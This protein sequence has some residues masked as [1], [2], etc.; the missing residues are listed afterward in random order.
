M[1]DWKYV[2]LEDPETG[3]KVPVI[4]PTELTHSDMAEAA[5]RSARRA[6]GARTYLKP[7]SAG[8][9]SIM[10]T[11]TS[12]M[13]ESLNL[14]SRPEDALTINTRPYTG[15]VESGLEKNIETML[16]VKHIE[17]LLERIKS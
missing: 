5:I 2:M 10:T 12:G 7:V 1:S 14:D 9:L 11:G 17:H 13:S 4:F 8:F 6:V 3:R 16:G 15:G